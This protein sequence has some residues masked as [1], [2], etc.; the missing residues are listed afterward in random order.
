MKKAQRQMLISFCIHGVPRTKKNSQQIIQVPIPGTGK[1]RPIPI[2]SKDYKQYREDFL[3]QIPGYAKKAYEEPLNLKCVYYMPTK[4]RVDLINLLEATCDILVDA[5][6]LA[7]DNCQIVVSHDGS[8][9]FY[10][11]NDSRVE[12][13]IALVNDDRKSVAN[14]D[15][16]SEDLHNNP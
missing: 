11:K 8:R 16:S 3:W 14:T 4:R 10:D 5:N 6:V 7:D 9:V 1:K 2:P 15:F 12:I 13:E